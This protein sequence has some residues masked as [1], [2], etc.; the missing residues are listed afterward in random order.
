MTRSGGFDF[1][2]IES[3]LETPEGRAKILLINRIERVI[4]S[5]FH[6]LPYSIRVLLENVVRHYDGFVVRDEDV[7][8][9]AR[10]GEYAGRKDV[11]FHPV[12]VVM[13]DFTGVPA[14]VD[15]AAMRDA[16]KQ[17]GGDPSKVNP[18]IPVDLIIDHSIQVDYYGTAEAFRLNLKREYERNRERYQLLKWAQ[19]AF[20]NFRVVPPGKGIIHQVNLEYLARVVWLSRRNGTLYAHPDSLLGTDSHTTMINGL[21]VFGWGVGGIEAEAVILGQP[22]YMLLPEV[23]GVRLVGELREGV[24][25]TDLVLYITEKLRKRNVVGK[26]VEYFGEGVKKLSVP[27]RATIANMA[28][29]YGATMGFFPVDE[30][31]IEYLRGTGRPEWL[32]QLVERYAKETGLWYSLEDPEPRYSDVVEI[33]LS[34]VEPSISGPSHPEDRIPLREAKERVRKII[35]EYL[36]KKGRGPAIVELKLGD[37]EVHLTDGSVVY[38]ALTSCT[39]TSN[40]SVMIAAALLARNAVKKGLR[41]RPWVKTSNAPGSRVVPEYWNRLGLMPYLEALG[42]HITG[43]GCTVCIGN[44]GPLRSEIEEAIREHDLWVATV[45]SGNRNFSGRIHPL[46]RGNFLASPPLVVAYALA[47]R[48]DIDFEKEPVGYDP[49]GNPVYLRDLW[50]SQREVREAI[51]SALDPQLFI[52]KYKDIDRGDR[53]WE[54]LEAP[55]GEL[56]GWD[57]KSTYIRKP[58]YFDNMP[59]EPQPPKDIRGARVL[60]WAPDRTST[61]HISPAGRISPDS[62]AGQYL[63]EQGVLPSQLNT[64]G[65]RRG[66]HEVM[67]RCTFDN[68]RF[69]NRLVPDREGGWTIFWPTGEVMHV[70][71]AAMK[72]R[73]MG[74][75][76]IVLAGKQYGVGSSRDWAAKG[77]ALLGV[78]AVIAESY[79]RI[80]RSNLVGMGVLPLEFM[81]G[82]NAEKLGL[83]GS[84]EYDIIGIEEGLHPGKI[85]TVRARKSDGRVIEFK[86]KARLDTPI[87]VEYYKHGGI[88]Q[89]VLRK[90]IREHGRGN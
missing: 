59:L 66:N 84:E 55:E 56:Y 64:C 35:L 16:M 78:K 58:P 30:A 80:H 9:V 41:T 46:A 37:E 2:P 40:P 88:L 69:R 33:D 17:F 74:I 21:G 8:A 44:S 65:S 45:L 76:L 26:F 79:E 50:P 57:P 14:V 28:P 81:P 75:P 32:V 36:E 22:Y 90:L 48:V 39:N 53:F 47:G 72:Y 73:E 42:F 60:V 61:D 15:L 62:K 51:E 20:S 71:D 7:E 1:K 63:I 38:A 89:Y 54:E 3:E 11:P 10:W 43:Y 34:D 4:P 12:R 86:V 6:S 29:E 83:D 27:D 85:L 49:N 23:V 31:T 5:D 70:F 13:Q 87:E 24:T 67:M 82:E 19:K 68:P 52:E 25:T 18:L 77:P